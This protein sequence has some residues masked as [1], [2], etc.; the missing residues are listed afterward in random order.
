MR[1]AAVSVAAI[2]LIFAAAPGA[3]ADTIVAAAGDIACGSGSTGL[4][5]QRSTSAVLAQINPNVV[6]TL[7]EFAGVSAALPLVSDRAWTA[8]DSYSVWFRLQSGV[9][10][11][12][13]SSA[14]DFTTDTLAPGTDYPYA[15]QRLDPVKLECGCTALARRSPSQPP[16][17]PKRTYGA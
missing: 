7:G 15:V 3:R 13:Q 5:A 8:E 11:V 17:G 12:L 10:G 1:R 4:C 14:G 2:A 9:E 6:L 16:T